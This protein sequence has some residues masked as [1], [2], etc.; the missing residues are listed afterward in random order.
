MDEKLLEIRQYLGEGYKPLIDF[1]TWRVAVLRWIEELEPGNITSMERHTQTDEVFVLLEGQSTIIL[2]G[3]SAMVD[4]IYPQ[5]LE[6]GKLYNVK[7][8]VWH[9][10]LLSRDASILIVENRNTG[11]VNSEYCQ[12][13]DE[14]KKQII[15]LSEV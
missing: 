9:T 12:L 2:G 13:T 6:P 1:D 5:K 3:D 14:F 7:R 4:G 8:D 10:V 15:E 11:E